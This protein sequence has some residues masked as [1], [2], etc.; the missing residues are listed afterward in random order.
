MRV[1]IPEHKTFVDFPD[2]TPP[3]E[4]QAVLAKSFPP[5]RGVVDAFKG[6]YATAARNL[7]EASAGVL[8]RMSKGAKFVE[9]TTGL[10]AGGAFEAGANTSRA[11]AEFWRGKEAEAGVDPNAIT[12]RVYGGVG[13]APVDIAEFVAGTPTAA[14]SGLAEGGPLEAFRAGA[15]RYGVGK[16][17]K[18]LENANLSPVQRSG[19]MAGTMAAQTAAE[20]GS[21]E[22]VVAAGITGLA[23]SA[24]TEGGRAG[25][26]RQNLQRAGVQPETA[27]DLSSRPEVTPQGMGSIDTTNMDRALPG[28]PAPRPLVMDAEAA[29]RAVTVRPVERGPVLD[30]ENPSLITR[31][32][33]IPGS[34]ALSMEIARTRAEHPDW[35]DADVWAAAEQAVVRNPEVLPTPTERDAQPVRREPVATAE[36]APRPSPL[37]PPSMEN[38]PVRSAEKPDS[39]WYWG[40]QEFDSGKSGT[41]ITRDKD[42]AAKFASQTG[43]AVHELALSPDARIY[44][45]PL[46]WQ[47]YANMWQKDKVFKGYDAVRVIEP[48]GQGESLTILNPKVLTKAA[49]PKEFEHDSLPT[50]AVTAAD[51]LTVPASIKAAVV[52]TPAEISAL[53]QPGKAVLRNGDKAYLIDRAEA[54]KQFG[55]LAEAKKML[56]AGGD[57]EAKV[58][59]YPSREGNGEKVKVYHGSNSATPMTP[60]RDGNTHYF[61]SPRPAR[62]YGKVHETEVR[63]GNPLTVDA[64]G[65]TKGEFGNYDQLIADAKANGNDAVIVKNV[66]DVPTDLEEGYYK[67]RLSRYKGDVVIPVKP[68]F[69]TEAVTK[70]GEILTEPGAIKQAASAGEVAY[71]AESTPAEVRA[72]TERVANSLLTEPSASGTV[73]PP[74]GGGDMAFPDSNFYFAFVK[75]GQVVHSGGEPKREFRGE[76]PD[77]RLI[78]TFQQMG[79]D[80]LLV[81]DKQIVKTDIQRGDIFGYTFDQINAMQQGGRKNGV[82][83]TVDTSGAVELSIPAE[84]GQREQETT[85]TTG[86]AR[87]A[88][89]AVPEVRGV[90]SPERDGVPVLQPADADTTTLLHAGVHVP[91]LVK[92]VYD[93]YFRKLD[94]DAAPGS[95]KEFLDKNRDANRK[96]GT[97]PI[98]RWLRRAGISNSANA[99]MELMNNDLPGAWARREFDNI[100]G[101]SAIAGLAKERMRKQLGDLSLRERQARADWVAI[102]ND[103]GIAS[104]GRTDYTYFGGFTPDQLRAARQTFQA[105]YKLTDAEFQR[106]RESA[107]NGIFG[108]FK[109]INQRLYEKGM[110]TEAELQALNS[111]AYSPK[112]YLDKIDPFVSMPGGGAGGRVSVPDSG[113]HR[114]KEGSDAYFRND[115]VALLEEAIDRSET[116]I[117]RNE[118][119]RALAALPESS[120]IVKPGVRLGVKDWADA[121]DGYE[122]IRYMENGQQQAVYIREDF[123]REWAEADPMLNQKVAEILRFVSGATTTRAQATGH[124]PLFPL[125]N[126]PVDALTIWLQPEVKGLSALG[127]VFLKRHA[128]NVKNVS[129][130]AWNHVGRYEEWVMQK[131]ARDMLTN[132]GSVTSRRAHLRPELQKV[133]DMTS[134]AGRFSEEASRLA[135][136]E[137]LLKDGVPAKEAS[138]IAGTYIDYSQGGWLIKAIDTVAPYLNAGVQGTR[139]IARSAGRDPALFAFKATQLLVAA[140]AV[141]NYNALVNPTGWA[142]VSDREKVENFIFML[143]AFFNYVDKD[144]TT[145]TPYIRIR[146]EQSMRPVLSAAD[147]VWQYAKEGKDPTQQLQMAIKDAN[148]LSLSKFI[149]PIQK[150]YLAYA[151]NRDVY[152]NENVWKGKQ[153]IEPYAEYTNTTN[154]ILTRIGQETQVDGKGGISPERF[155]RALGQVLLPTNLF[156][157]TGGALLTSAY[158]KMNPQERAEFGKTNYEKLVGFMKGTRLLGG[159]KDTEQFREGIREARVSTNTQLFEM[160]KPLDAMVLKY[161]KEGMTDQAQY[162]KILSYIDSQPPE[163]QDRLESRMEDVI[164]TANLPDRGWWLAV[165]ALSP[166]DRAD[167]FKARLEKVD[168]AEQERMMQIAEELTGFVSDRFWERYDG[169]A[170][171][172][173]V[174]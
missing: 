3:E 49:R 159:A 131:G 109:N 22:D 104:T 119:N 156:T 171:A 117:A 111:R 118:A 55:S 172:T 34:D 122:T 137:M 83:R 161:A 150:A 160:N 61:T 127:P 1:D 165:K 14:L 153:E 151:Q 23:L 69:T 80:K 105:D 46:W 85:A 45:E 73:S 100:N 155:G 89:E 82:T 169:P 50:A 41:F 168:R 125:V 128:E 93:K 154:P 6:A 115:P 133:L 162:D 77:N 59:G 28:E 37:N 25:R 11:N 98:M 86:E 101:A 15:T 143:P 47:D 145:V 174:P 51:S 71:A 138:H 10:P 108:G 84:R 88:G 60:D 12:T 33:M 113:I 2:N 65:M 54:A 90:A 31:D 96:W 94:A 70:S 107:D 48:N 170:Q 63:I 66:I 91:T 106:V 57:A 114:L 29:P 75:D 26:I 157:R 74:K 166:E 140:S 167:Q 24:P 9:R 58:L 56:L 173:N 148:P 112:Q 95:V 36:D 32:P 130:D 121:P 44:P 136:R 116:R 132:Y 139:S 39:G 81:S 52:G 135:F 149:M 99:Q 126:F 79:A 102:E 141:Y 4:I 72:A 164:E 129:K 152:R 17:F 53:V 142:N 67:N 43:G 120:G 40:G 7:N 62:L 13:R 147:A 5:K 110:I 20:G 163:H 19:A 134:K 144:G 146:K 35:R 16:V 21:V 68:E 8:D 76:N 78:G 38:P 64:R 87:P 92:Q 124:N 97:E 158:E 27:H 123:A 18:G 103:L 42:Y 30:A